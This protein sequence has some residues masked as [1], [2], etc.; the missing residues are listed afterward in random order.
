MSPDLAVTM[1]FLGRSIVVVAILFSL[2]SRNVVVVASTELLEYYPG[3]R[4]DLLDLRDTMTSTA[5]LHKNWTGPPCIYNSSKWVGVSCSNGHVVG[6]VLEGIQLT[7]VLPP[8]FL[9]NITFL[10]RLSLR[11]NVIS[12]SLPNLT[13]LV[14]LENVLLSENRFTGNIPVQ[15][16]GLG[17]L[18]E[19]ELQ[20][21][22]LVGQ[23]PAFNQSTL[24]VFNVSYNHL[25]GPIPQT[26]VLQSFPESSYD[27]NSALCGRPLR[28]FCPA[29]PPTIITPP[30]A[31]SPP[32]PARGKKKRLKIWSVVFIAAAAAL[33]PFL[34]ILVFLCYYRKMQGKETAKPEQEGM[35]CQ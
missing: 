7:G 1:T 13:N 8:A 28:N 30:P 11:N 15:Y 10:N 5:N 34:V 32:I 26:G 33:V 6:L 31:A 9:Q 29:P 22:Y 4:Q 24:T 27:N 35:L 19:L 14:S 23:I 17:R 18:R 3:E 2:F 20:E 12:G 21:N 25:N 16:I